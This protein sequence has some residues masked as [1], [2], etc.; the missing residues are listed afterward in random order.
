M[1]C[2]RAATRPGFE[3]DPQP[4][5]GGDLAFEGD[6][7]GVAPACLGS[8]RQRAAL[9]EALGGADIEAAANHLVGE[10]RGIGGGEKGA[11]M[12]GGEFAG[13]EPA[14]APLPA[15]STVAACWRHGCGSCR[16]HRRGSPGYGRIP[17]ATGHRR[18]PLRAVRGSRAGCFRRV[19]FRAPRRRRGRGRRPGLRAARRAVRHATAARRRPVRN[20]ASAASTGRT[21]SGCRMPFSRIDWASASSSASAKALPRLQ[22][23]RL[24]QLD[25]HQPLVCRIERDLAVALAEERRQTAAERPAFY[26]FAHAGLASARRNISAASRI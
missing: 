8:R 14:A 19:L 24:D 6:G 26:S 4:E 11:G 12:T 16:P 15:G 23:A 1:Q 10:C 13:V 5:R 2:Q 25:R 17:P 22:C 18:R 21:S 20:A 3:R 7:V 9:N